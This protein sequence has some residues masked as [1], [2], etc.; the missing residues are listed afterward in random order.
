MA[1][2]GVAEQRVQAVRLAY[3]LGLDQRQ[4]VSVSIEQGHIPTRDEELLCRE[5]TAWTCAQAPA[6]QDP[7]GADQTHA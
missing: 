7:S 3:M 2:P 4:S 5:R 1:R 6:S